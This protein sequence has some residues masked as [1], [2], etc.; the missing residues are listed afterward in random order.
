MF[1]LRVCYSLLGKFSLGPSDCMV[2]FVVLASVL[3]LGYCPFVFLWLRR[4]CGYRFGARASDC[5]CLL[6]SSFGLRVAP[7]SL[8]DL[9]RRALAWQRLAYAPPGIKM[10]TVQ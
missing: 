1:D 6:Q 4:A 10:V 7:E 3:H 9:L 5:L 2:E 8:W